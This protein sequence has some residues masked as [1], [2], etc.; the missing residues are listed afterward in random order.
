MMR[1][2]CA[3]RILLPLLLMATAAPANA[4]ERRFTITGFERVR[5]D[6]PFSVTLTTNSAPFARARGSAAALDRVVIEM[7]GRTLVVRRDRTGWGG[8]PGDADQ[9]VEIALGTHELAG[10][11]VNGSGSL[12][13]D[14]ARGL[15][16]DLSVS[17]AGSAEIASTDVD[18][19]RIGL[20][21]TATS[22]VSGKA[23]RLSAS[24]DGSSSL[25]AGELTVKDAII[26]SG[27]PANV[28]LTATQTAKVTARG[29]ATVALRGR[30]ACANRLEGSAS[31]SGCK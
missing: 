26:T 8:N 21:G 22:K 16:F 27:G 28:E 13:I 6:G 5:V 9:S 19:L 15:K 14:R 29:A 2:E 23:L 7:Q 24:V 4:A 31:V 17:G 25:Q 11:W 18:Q 30:P 20:L 1:Q 10:A 12:A 3:M